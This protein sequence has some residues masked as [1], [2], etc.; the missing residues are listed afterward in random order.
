MPFKKKKTVSA[1]HSGPWIYCGP[2]LPGVVKRNTIL[3]GSLPPLLEE[4]IT[5]CPEIKKLLVPP[6]RLQGT[7][8][9]VGVAGTAENLFY[10]RILEYRKE[11]K[12]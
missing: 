9:R 12:V 8:E 3:K 11:L 5:R 2:E 7:R 10:S 6:Q 4:Q 1:A